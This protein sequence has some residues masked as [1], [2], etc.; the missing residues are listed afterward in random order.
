VA[1][2]LDSTYTAESLVHLLLKNAQKKRKPEE[3]TWHKWED[4]IK[5]DIKDRVGR[6]G[7]D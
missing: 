6:C 4:N 3:T 2:S 5:V 1:F 7:I